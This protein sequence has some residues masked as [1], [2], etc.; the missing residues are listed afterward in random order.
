[1]GIGEGYGLAKAGVATLT[2]VQAKTYPNLKAVC[3]HPGFIDTPMHKGYG[4][5]LTPEQ[6]CVS[7]LK[8]LFG[9]VTSGCYY[10][11]D[12]SEGGEADVPHMDALEALLKARGLWL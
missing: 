7:S 11:S 9:E 5:T 6:G 12:G 2:L 4:A 10:A 1:M 8:C 3:L